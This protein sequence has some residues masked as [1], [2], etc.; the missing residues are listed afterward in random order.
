MR[1]RVQQLAKRLAAQ[2]SSQLPSLRTTTTTSSALPRLA[3][4][5]RHFTT[6]MAPN[7]TTARLV[8]VRQLMKDKHVDIYGSLPSRLTLCLLLLVV[9]SEDAHQSEYVC[10]AD[11]RREF[12]SG[13]YLH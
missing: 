4:L 6:A 11:K 9:P 13:T 5:T 1:N 12:I 8:E 2:T 10:A 7:R 3:L